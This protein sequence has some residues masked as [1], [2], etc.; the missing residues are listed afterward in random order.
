MCIPDYTFQGFI[1]ISYNTFRL[2]IKWR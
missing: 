1:I 2:Y